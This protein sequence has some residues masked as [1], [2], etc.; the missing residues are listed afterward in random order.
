[1]QAAGYATYYTGKLF[2]SHTIRNYDKPFPAA[3]TESDFLIDPGTYSYLNPIFQ[4]GRDEPVQHHDSHTSD[5]IAEKA[6]GLLERA[7][8]NDKPFFLTVAPI[9]PHS[10]IDVNSGGPPMMTEPI[11]PERHAHLFEGVQVPRTE[12]FNPDEVRHLQEDSGSRC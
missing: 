4:H 11:P 3:W 6:H 9:A 5:L 2:N 10:N 12:N 7:I 1:M 8:K